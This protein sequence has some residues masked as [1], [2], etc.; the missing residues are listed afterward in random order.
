M[1]SLKPRKIFLRLWL[2]RSKPKSNQEQ[3]RILLE[4][5]DQSLNNLSMLTLRDRQQLTVHLNHS[6]WCVVINVSLSN[7]HCKC[8]LRSICKIFDICPITKLN[9]SVISS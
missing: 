9:F 2:K 7:N 4:L 5:A 8:F 6:Q 1:V 3:E